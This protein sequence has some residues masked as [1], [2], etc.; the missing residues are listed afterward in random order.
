MRILW[1]ALL[2]SNVMYYVLTVISGR[3]ENAEPNPTLFLILIAIG[4]TTALISF[5]VKNTLLARALQQ[6]QVP[7]V[8]QAYVTAWALSEVPAL[9][10]VIDFFVMG[11]RY[12][13]VLLIISA[14]A[15][16]LHF[17]RREHVINAW[18]KTPIA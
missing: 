1:I 13:Y 4:I 11:D 18:A 14:C 16:L 9:L 15:Q 5:F 12:F 10:G 2:M 3:S 17:P 6:Q 8:Q 7:M